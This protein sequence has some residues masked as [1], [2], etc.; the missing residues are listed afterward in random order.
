MKH[1]DMEEHEQEFD[2]AE[3]AEDVA[4][5]TTED[6]MDTEAAPISEGMDGLGLVPDL[7][8]EAQVEA[9]VFASPTPVRPAEV[10]DYLEQRISLKQAETVLDALVESHALRAGGFKLEYIKGFG[11][12]FRTDAAAAPIM[13]RMFA[14][15]PRPISRAALETLSII[16]YR[17]PVTRAEIEFIRGV[18]AGSIIKN[19]LERNLISCVGRKEEAGRPMIFGTTNEFLKVFRLNSLND[20]PPLTSFQPPKEVVDNALAQLTN[21][22]DVDVEEYIGDSEKTEPLV[23]EGLV[24]AEAAESWDEDAPAA[25]PSNDE[26]TDHEQQDRG[27]ENSDSEVAVE[28]GDS[29]EATGRELDRSQEDLG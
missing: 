2:Q 4:M 10:V 9:I 21:T 6:M 12:Q 27:S 5:E 17:Q 19:L 1:D 13:E 14:T 18:D 29:L 25:V 11:Y 16:A 22:G 15:R 8:I 20:L 26:I 7:S 3:V 28:P 24:G 23:S